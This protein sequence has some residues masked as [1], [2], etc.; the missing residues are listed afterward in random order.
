MKTALKSKNVVTKSGIKEAIV[1]IEEGLIKEILNYSDEIDCE[2]TDYGGL[3]IMPGLIDTHVHINEPGRT[4]W[5]GFETATR[6]AAAGGITML[7]DMPLNSSPVTT[8]ADAFNVKAAAARNKLSVDCGFYGGLVPGNINELKGLIRKGVFGLKAFMVDSGIEDFPFV[9]EN[10]LRKALSVISEYKI[11]LLVHAEIDCGFTKFTGHE[12]FSYNSFLRKRPD[13]WEIRAIEVLIKLCRDFNFHIHIVHL[14]S[15][16]AIELIREAKNEGLK[17][18]CETCPH[19]LIFSSEDISGHDTRFKCTPP[20]RNNAN[21][22]KLWAAVKDGVID[23]IVSDHSPCD[24]D[25]KCH[26]EGNFEKAWGGISGL[27]LGLSAVWTEARKRG[28][29]V[30]D[31]SKLMSENTASFLGLGNSAGK[32]EKG[33][34]ANLTVFDPDKKFRVN[35][36]ILYHRHKLTPYSGMELYGTIEATYLRG[37]MIFN[38]D[39]IISYPYGELKKSL[40]T[41]KV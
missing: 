32:I 4:E 15:S 6:S 34:E 5:E 10:D 19:Y 8:S 38:Q 11:P 13:E 30:E 40:N 1:V 24:P 39:G 21:R 25:L 35:E 37:K 36:D 20:I 18:T 16:Y 31:V 7:V 23:F 2:I 12:E 33:F 9:N 14:S 3:V 22:E 29:K 28:F 26:E 27:Q 17:L 41:S